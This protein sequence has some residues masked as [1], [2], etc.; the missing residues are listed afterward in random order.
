M[1]LNVEQNME[2]NTFKR[3]FIYSKA[4]KWQHVEVFMIK[5]IL[6]S[7][8]SGGGGQVENGSS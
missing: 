6:L 1:L 8:I 3:T 5:W 2:R 7:H 4:I